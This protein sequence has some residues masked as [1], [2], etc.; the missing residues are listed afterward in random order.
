M[1]ND[2]RRGL[3]AS[4]RAVKRYP[5]ELQM[6]AAAYRFGP[7][8]L[9]SGEH[10]LT[11]DGV[12]VPLSPKAF[13]LLHL[14]VQRS[15]SLLEKRELFASLWPE[16]FVEEANLSVQVAAIRKALRPCCDGA[17]ETVSKRGYRFTAP[18]EQVDA[19]RD[20]AD[21]GAAVR[22]LVQP[23]R[24]LAPNLESEFLSRSLPD[25]IASTLTGI[26]WLSVRAPFDLHGPGAPRL[27]PT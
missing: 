22:L 21:A 20:H 23:L 17:I 10:I 3:T 9:R 6:P 25:A 7:F 14:L 18:V 13:D 2:S 11:R 4:L 19:H 8:E 5:N 27:V 26:P 12:H 1:A 16:T 24:V 15:G